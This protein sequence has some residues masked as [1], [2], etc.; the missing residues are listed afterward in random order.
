MILGQGPKVEQFKLI[1]YTLYKYI[2][3]KK[4]KK[5]IPT[6]ISNHMP[7]KVWNEITDPFPNFNG[8]AIEV[9]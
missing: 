5:K 6:W 3:K 8:E 1:G 4:K 2:W 7:C 9:W